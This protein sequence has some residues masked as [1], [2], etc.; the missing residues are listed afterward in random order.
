MVQSGN[1]VRTFTE[2]MANLSI[3]AVRCGEISEFAVAAVGLAP[4]KNVGLRVAVEVHRIAGRQ[5]LDSA[6][7]VLKDVA[8]E[9]SSVK[10]KSCKE[11][12]S[13]NVCSLVLF[14]ILRCI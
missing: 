7:S 3:P 1:G 13:V 8:D 2:N 14:A 6:S 4:Q 5:T 12:P 10:V 9:G 11:R